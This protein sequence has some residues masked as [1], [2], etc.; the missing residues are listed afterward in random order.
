M[1]LYK[2]FWLY[3]L[4]FF[5]L[6]LF[7]GG[8]WW[9][10]DKGT[11]E[12]SVAI[13]SV[14]G[15]VLCSQFFVMPLEIEKYKYTLSLEKKH[16]TYTKLFHSF[17]NL[18]DPLNL[19]ALEERPFGKLS[20]EE[21]QNHIALKNQLGEAGDFFHETINENTLYL[22]LAL[23]PIIH[24]ISKRLLDV[25]VIFNQISGSI[26]EQKAKEQFRQIV[27]DINQLIAVADEIAREELHI[28]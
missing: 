25:S 16:I 10:Y 8:A 3:V 28:K 24:K 27:E 26:V 11:L 21:K 15:A 20:P 4:W 13:I 7:I 17:N 2:R 18:V 22:S 12:L 19:L 23:R 9:F 6:A 14:M 5:T 1:I